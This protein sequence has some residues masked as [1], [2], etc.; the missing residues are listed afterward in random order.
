MIL[1]RASYY[2]KT[3]LNV[4]VPGE[5]H[6]FDIHGHHRGIKHIGDFG[7]RIAVTWHLKRHQS[8]A[9]A[10]SETSSKY[11]RRFPRHQPQYTCMF[12]RHHPNTHAGSRDINPNTHAGSRDIN[13]NTHAGFRDIDPNT[14]AGSETSFIIQIVEIQG[15]IGNIH[16]F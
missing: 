5:C 10:G 8:K 11:T 1:L 6:D 9:H 14:H 3:N 12:P 2:I 16:G 7:V 13:H 15:F 4:H